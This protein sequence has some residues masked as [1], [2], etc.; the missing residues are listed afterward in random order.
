MRQREKKIKG[1]NEKIIAPIMWVWDVQKFS[2]SWKTIGRTRT[3]SFTMIRKKEG[4]KRSKDLD[5][6]M[7][8]PT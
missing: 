6:Y 1:K 5:N 7:L 2:F 8:V 3:L 4:N